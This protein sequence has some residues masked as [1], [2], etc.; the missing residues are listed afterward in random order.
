MKTCHSDYGTLKSVYV[1]PV[2]HSFR[3]QKQLDEEWDTLN[4]LSCPSYEGSVTEYQ[5]FISLLIRE[6]VEINTFETDDS[7][8]IDSIYCR[9]ASIATDSGV[10]ICR[11]GKAGRLN[12]PAA[13]KKIFRENG[14]PILGEI[15]PSGTVEGGDVAWLDDETL[16]V[17][18]SYRTNTEGI[19][20]LTKLLERVEVNVIPVE[21][22]HYK[23]RS[24][25][26]HL[27]SI[28][29]P[30]D[31]N[32]ALTYSP[33]MPIN[34]RCR[35]L[36]MGYQLVEVPDEEFETMG[37]N[38]LALGPRKCLMVSGN[39]IVKQRLEEAGCT[40]LEYNGNEISIP[41]GG[42]PT[43]LTRPLWRDI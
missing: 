19:R 24:D 38:V 18:H 34:F 33:L 21:L 27:M 43:C 25:V 15:L 6:G 32:L 13:Q 42:G 5:K 2:V 37:S 8:T 40:V 22:P 9:D 17:G 10:I 16:A 23:G 30:L 39:P 35:L 26:F 12:E 20:Q 31:H 41:G 1:K 3:S 7:V 29:S 28:L 4:Y 36:D 14:V 11:M